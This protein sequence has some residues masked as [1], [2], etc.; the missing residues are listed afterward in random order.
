ME[1]DGTGAVSLGATG[2]DLPAADPASRRFV[3]IYGAEGRELR[4]FPMVK[5]EGRKLYELPSG[6]RFKYVRWDSAGRRIF[7]VTGNRLA[8]ALDATSGR[9]LSEETLP[10]V[11]AGPYDK[12]IGAAF[13]DDA[14]IQAYSVAARSSTLY[15]LTGLR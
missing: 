1:T 14:K 13:S 7:A 10:L 11:G 8:M 12:L 3:C 2:C 9:V 5:G 15:Q 6:T 4:V